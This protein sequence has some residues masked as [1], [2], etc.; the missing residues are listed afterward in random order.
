MDLGLLNPEDDS[1]AI[2][3]NVGS[4]SQ[5]ANLHQHCCKELKCHHQ[6]KAFVNFAKMR[7]SDVRISARLYE[8]VGTEYIAL[9]CYCDLRVFLREIN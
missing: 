2:L 6:P 8:E 5:D 4:Y 3:R 1:I 7:P 9:I